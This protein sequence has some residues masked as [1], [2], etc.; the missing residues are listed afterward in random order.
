MHVS[1]RKEGYQLWEVVDC[2]NG[3]VEVA[4]ILQTLQK[5]ESDL[6]EPEMDYIEAMLTCAE[7][8]R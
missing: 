8:N 2:R 3:K 7:H 1:L 6:Q 5:L 4:K